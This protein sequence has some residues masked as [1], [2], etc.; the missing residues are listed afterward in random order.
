MRWVEVVDVAMATVQAAVA[1][2]G[3]VAVKGAAP[4]LPGRAATAFA[5]VVGTM[6]RT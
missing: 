1:A 3:V 4:W 2:A 6:S 5:P